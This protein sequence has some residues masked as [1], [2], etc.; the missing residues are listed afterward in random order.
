MKESLLEKK[1][2]TKKIENFEE[3]LAELESIAH[4]LESGELGMDDAIDR[5]GEG[6]EYARFCQKKLDEAERRIEILQKT[7]NGSIEKT[8]IRIKGD[9]GEIED[10]DDVQGSL[11]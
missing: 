2:K 3:A 8:P 7:K 4:E 10:E 1:K 9:T 11:L 5:Y 6:I